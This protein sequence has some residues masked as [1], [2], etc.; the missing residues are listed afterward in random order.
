MRGA[1]TAFVLCVVAVAIGA[2][3]LRLPRLSLRPM[4]GDEANQAVKTAILL[5]TGQ[6]AYNPHDH[7]GPSLYYLALPVLWAAGAETAPDITDAM[8]RLVPV[9]FGV[10]LVLLVLFVA[11][12]LGRPA[13]AVAAALAA[14]SPALVFYSRY[15]VQEMLLLFFTFGLIATAWRY[16]VSRKVAWAAAAGACLGLMHATKETWVLAG[17]SMLAALVLVLLWERYGDRRVLDLRSCLT[18]RALAAALVAAAVVAGILYT[19]FFTHGRGPLDSVLTYGYNVSKAGGESIHA[20][21]W[22]WYLSM[23]AFSRFVTGAG[24]GP[25]WSEALI[26]GLALVGVVAA[27]AGRG[28]GRTHRGLARFLALYTVFLT[29]AYALIRYKTPWCAISFLHG[30]VLLAGIGAVA[31]VRWVPTRPLKVLV[32][33]VL[34]AGA[35]HLGWQAH[36]AA[37]RFPADQRNPYVY[38][39]TAPDALKLVARVEEVAEVSPEGHDMIVKVITPTNYWPLPWYLRNFTPGHVGYY[40]E[41]PEDVDAS[42]IITSPEWTGEI[43]G[44]ARDEYFQCIHG[45]RPGVLMSVWIRQPLWDALVAKWTAEAEAAAPPG[46]G[47]AP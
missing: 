20:H 44:R 4:H 28:L 45:L 2:A 30:M 7:H 18:G 37:F 29:V 36:R 42:V 10:G 46:Q 32:A 9:L 24:V 47:E 40:H 43:E 38:A 26:L 21:P 33:V 22:H 5:E 16:V 19:S 14:V 11:D 39:H 25:W 15:Y 27:V 1:R 3:A 23:L 41:V 12:G 31:L 13:A 34:A 8:L 35:V 6:Y 17:A